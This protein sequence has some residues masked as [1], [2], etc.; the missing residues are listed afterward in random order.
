MPRLMRPAAVARCEKNLR[1]DP[2][3]SQRAS[4][5]SSSWTCRPRVWGLS[6]LKRVCVCVWIVFIGKKQWHGDIR[7]NY[8]YIMLYI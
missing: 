1:W 6:V 7:Y 5:I 3:R 2:K 4:C 8:S